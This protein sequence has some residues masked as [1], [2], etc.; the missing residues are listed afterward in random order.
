MKSTAYIMVA[1][2]AVEHQGVE[3]I[4]LEYLYAWDANERDAHRAVWMHKGNNLNFWNLLCKGG[5][6]RLESAFFLKLS[7]WIASARK[8]SVQTSVLKQI[9]PLFAYNMVL[10]WCV[11]QKQYITSYL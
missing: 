7:V 1:N 8:L 9:F 3:L 2:N 10:N 11:F 6:T 4:R 5:N